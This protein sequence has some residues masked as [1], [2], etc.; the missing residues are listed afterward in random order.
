MKKELKMLFKTRDG[1]TTTLTMPDPKADL[2]KEAIK[3][4]MLTVI[5]KNVFET[6]NGELVSPVS[7]K[8]VETSEVVYE[9]SK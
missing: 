3:A 2:D 9:V 4:A 5:E 1:S 6:I 8:V 7:A